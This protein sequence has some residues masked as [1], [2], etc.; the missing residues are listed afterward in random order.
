MTCDSISGERWR[1]TFPEAEA[2]FFV[3]VLAHLREHYAR[4]LDSMPTAQRTYWEQTR[5]PELTGAAGEADAP[6]DDESILGDARAELRSQRLTLAE[7]WVHDFELADS[8]DPWV[9]ELSAAERD[10]FVAML[11]DRRLLLALEIGLTD[12]DMERHQKPL[13][14]ND[15]RTVA[16]LEIDLLGHF[17]V[18]MLGPQIY[19]A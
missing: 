17:I 1:L 19:R 14:R 13:K 15:S 18:V 11:N 3:N 8:R 6:S 7:N 10:E 4:D 9:V 12:N 2:L 16:I 5:S